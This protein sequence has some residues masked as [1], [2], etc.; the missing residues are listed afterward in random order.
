MDNG[1]AAKSEEGKNLKLNGEKIGE[2][3]EVSILR[4]EDFENYKGFYN[5]I[6][7]VIYSVLLLVHI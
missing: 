3:L 2:P 7:L 4:E 1:P 6:N 5:S